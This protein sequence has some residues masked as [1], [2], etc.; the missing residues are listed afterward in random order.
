MSF[1]I[2]LLRSLN[3]KATIRTLPH[4]FLTSHSN[5]P[6]QNFHTRAR[7]IPWKVGSL[8][9]CSLF[10][11]LPCVCYITPKPVFS[12]EPARWRFLFLRNKTY[13]NK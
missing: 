1:S 4:Y 11:V 8:V 5:V 2:S 6:S 7:Y 3:E 9:Y 13:Y 12:F 10:L